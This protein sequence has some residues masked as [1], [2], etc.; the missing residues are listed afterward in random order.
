MVEVE[1]NKLKEILDKQR[2]LKTETIS[3]ILLC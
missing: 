2:K 1:E 3:R